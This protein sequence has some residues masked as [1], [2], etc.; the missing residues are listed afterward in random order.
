VLYQDESW[1]LIKGSG[2]KIALVVPDQHPPHIGFEISKSNYKTLK[3]QGRKF[4]LHRDSSESAYI[5]DPS[6]NS[7]ELVYWEG[8]Y[9]K[10]AK[11]KIKEILGDYKL[12]NWIK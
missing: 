11:T 7:V 6:G 1:S 12:P 4:K 2:V 8:S 3:K 5:A 9:A 10:K